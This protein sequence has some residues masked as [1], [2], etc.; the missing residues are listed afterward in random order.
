MPGC[1]HQFYHKGSVQRHINSY[2]KKMKNHVCNLC[3]KGF[4]QAVYLKE[5]R[6][7]HTNEFPNPCPFPGCSARFKQKSR[8]PTHLKSAHGVVQSRQKRPSKNKTLNIKKK[9]GPLIKKSAKV[10]IQ[11]NDKEKKF[12]TDID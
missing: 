8:I 6:N 2:H 4:S 7:I 1:K 3:G 11:L 10:V 5:H 9:A 12:A